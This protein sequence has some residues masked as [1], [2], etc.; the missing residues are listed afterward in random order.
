M[1]KVQML[2]LNE[3]D[4][5]TTVYQNLMVWGEEIVYFDCNF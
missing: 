2:H 5:E 3:T 4:S 1:T